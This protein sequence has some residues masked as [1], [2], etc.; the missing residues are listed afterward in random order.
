MERGGKGHLTKLGLL[1]LKVNSKVSEQT[2]Q[3]QYQYDSAPRMVIYK[4]KV[5]YWRP[6]TWHV[7]EKL[8]FQC[9]L[10]SGDAETMIYRNRKS[11][12]EILNYK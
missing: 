10:A 1:L 2:P 7:P 5:S 11:W 6:S 9:I 4:I 8:K 12:D 3:Q